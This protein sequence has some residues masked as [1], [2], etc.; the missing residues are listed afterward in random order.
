MRYSE[1]IGEELR[2]SGRIRAD[3]IVQGKLGEDL[4]DQGK[5][6]EDLRGNGRSGEIRGGPERKWEV[7][8]D[9]GRILE[10]L[11]GSGSIWEI[12][13]DSVRIRESLVRFGEKRGETGRLGE[14]GG[15]SG[16]S[17]RSGR[18]ANDLEL[19]RAASPDQTTSVQDPPA[20]SVTDRAGQALGLPAPGLTVQ[21]RLPTGAPG[22]TTGIAPSAK[23]TLGSGPERPA[24][25][26]GSSSF[27][28]A[29]SLQSG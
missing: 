5:F 14:K 15:V 20:L 1:R 16:E 21:A 7:G 18:E 23:A 12:Q 8:G 28:T 10:K 27:T 13:E 22:R 9:S 19:G 4:G 2:E 24:P 26:T 17:G 11:G 25:I 6:G 3:L 29:I